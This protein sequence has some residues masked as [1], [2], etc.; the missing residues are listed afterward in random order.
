MPEEFLNI[1]QD[2]AAYQCIG[3]KRVRNHESDRGSLVRCQNMSLVPSNP[4]RPDW[5]FLCSDCAGAPAVK[6]SPKTETVNVGAMQSDPE[7]YKDQMEAGLMMGI[8]GSD[9]NEDGE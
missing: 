4:A 8:R 6:N 1:A 3:Q 2:G 5:G 9:R 7:E